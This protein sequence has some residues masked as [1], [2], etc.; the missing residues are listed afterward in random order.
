[1][2]PYGRQSISE[3]DIAAVTAVLRS[4]LITQGPATEAFERV[5]AEYCGAKHAVAACNGT[6]A[7]HLGCMALGLGPGGLLWTSPNTFVASANCARYVGADVDF[8]DIDPA[9][10]NMS[11]D[12]L[13]A[14]LEVA[15]REGRLPDVVVPV[16]FAGVSCDLE[17][18]RRLADRYGF[19]VL[20][21][22]AH[23]IGGRYR[24]EPVGSCRY[25][26]ATVFSFHPVKIITTGEGG[27]VLTNDDAVA[28]RVRLLRTHGIT[29]DESLMDGASDGLWYYQQVDLGFN[30]RITDI[31]AALGISQMRRID[32][33]V[34]RRNEIAAAYR[35][36][37]TGLRL[38][39][40]V[41]PEDVLSAYHLFMIEVE[42]HDRA[43]VFY[44]LRELGVG[45]HVHYIPV[46]LQ[47]YYRNLGFAPG[48]F[49]NAEAYYK[50]A[51]TLPLYPQM[52]GEDLG[53]VVGAVRRMLS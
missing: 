39:V 7:L 27:M 14:K 44:A 33:F 45:T 38:G 37:F 21:D 31:Q 16:D 25:S 3:E 35:D 53:T 23:A 36:A 30:Y 40:Q 11:V 15:E 4:D 42:H 19:K 43:E 10:Y 12:A 29:R 48:D 6:A 46:H 5:V 20:E 13:A 8:V 28:E 47:P 32:E 51:I 26:D 2:I 22:A 9:T 34:A 17:G 52:T 50:R 24:D 49:P 18:I 41:I 1:M